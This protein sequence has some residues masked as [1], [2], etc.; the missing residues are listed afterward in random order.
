MVNGMLTGG[1]LLD[2]FSEL[3]GLGDLAWD[4]GALAAPA[5][6]AGRAEAFDARG[7][8][9]LPGCIDLHVHLR[10]PGREEAETVATGCLAAARGG[11]TRLGVM[12]NTT[13]PLDSPAEVAALLARG[14]R[15]GLARLVPCACL[16]RGRAGLEVADLEALA[17]AGAGAFTDDGSTVADES[18]LREAMR[19]AARL[20]L[21]VFDHALDPACRGHLHEGFK[22][23]AL[24]LEGVPASAEIRFVE[25]DIRLSE[26][27]GC[28]LHIQ[29]V[30]AAESVG[31]IRQARARGLRVT[32][33]ATPHH[34]ALTD[35]DIP[36][37]DSNFKM[38]PPLRTARDR[39]ALRE[40]VV[41]GVI[42]V[43]ATDHAPHAPAT[44]ARG[45]AA[46]PN[47]VMG[48]ETA[49]AV[50][51]D[52]L[53]RQMGMAPLEWVRRWTAGPAA[54]LNLPAPSLAPGA[55][56]DVVVFD[57]A[58]RWTVR[59]AQFASPS[60]NTPFEGW[61]LT[62]RVVR[63]YLGGELKFQVPNLKS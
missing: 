36:R 42:G 31:L 32:G 55:P 44:K 17:A 48:L 1:R 18:V 59:S 5:P 57:P 49:L 15:A 51:Y 19:R 35:A 26:E 22:S 53:V 39:A 7:L 38:S 45:F 52:I 29:H 6:P 43:L 47:G 62:G 28:A 56:A 12:P 63:T 21:P 61:E 58:A 3:D 54:V 25:R 4:G 40:A 16:T 23:A 46:A 50:T 33:E 11:L 41:E 13:P 8:W 20:G 2:P 9:V 60:R 24:G 37:A 10:E 30:S 27:T 34:L 14:A